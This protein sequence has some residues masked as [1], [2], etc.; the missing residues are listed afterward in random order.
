MQV[1][2]DEGV[3]GGHDALFTVLACS[4]SLLGEKV[5]SQGVFVCG[6]GKYWQLKTGRIPVT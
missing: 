1:R 5:R 6:V 4:W 2:V 3:H